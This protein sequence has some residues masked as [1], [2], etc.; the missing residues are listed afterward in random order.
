MITIHERRIPFSTDQFIKGRHRVLNTIQHFGESCGNVWGL[1]NVLFFFTSAY[2]LYIGDTSPT[3]ISFGV[4]QI[5]KKGHL[6]TLTN[7]G[8]KWVI[9]CDKTNYKWMLPLLTASKTWSFNPIARVKLIPKIDK[10][11][12]I[13]K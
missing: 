2:K 1:V 6:P 3:D 4:K 11:S 10:K 9:K 7:P 8:C 13:N 12:I 5:P